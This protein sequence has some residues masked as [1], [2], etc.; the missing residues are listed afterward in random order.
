M[1]AFRGFRNIEDFDVIGGFGEYFWLLFYAS[2]TT[3]VPMKKRF[4]KFQRS[5]WGRK[6][7]QADLKSR[8]MVLLHK[9]F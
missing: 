6:K 2:S 1:Q 7:E 5:V 3:S 8:S 9:V 4:K